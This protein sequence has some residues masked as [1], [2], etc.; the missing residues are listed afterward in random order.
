MNDRIVTAEGWT[1]KPR[2]MT[3]P[4]EAFVSKWQAAMRKPTPKP[5]DAALLPT[6]S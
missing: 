6:V 3:K 4:E 5:F 2:A 1:L